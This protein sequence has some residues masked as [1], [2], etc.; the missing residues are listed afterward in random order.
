MEKKGSQIFS[1]IVR[2]SKLTRQRALQI[3]NALLH[4]SRCWQHWKK[5]QKKNFLNHGEL[6]ETIK[7]PLFFLELGNNSFKPLMLKL[8][9][10]GTKWLKHMIICHVWRYCK[11]L[12]FAHPLFTA[13]CSRLNS[14]VNQM[15]NGFLSDSVEITSCEYCILKQLF[16]SGSINVVEYLRICSCLACVYRVIDARGKFGEH[17]RC[18][19]G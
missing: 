8:T 13:S 9:K 5:R 3:N 1:K 4:R 16:T 7:D 15:V 18:V 11:D 12:T 10:I 19:R 6:T 2:A 17:G 14:P